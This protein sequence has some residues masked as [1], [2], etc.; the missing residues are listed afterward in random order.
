MGE[1]AVLVKFGQHDHLLQL[2]QDGLLY[3]NNLPFFWEIE[4]QHRG[5]NCDGVLKITR[6]N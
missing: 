2:H 4:D 3:M 5:D 1:K 6:G